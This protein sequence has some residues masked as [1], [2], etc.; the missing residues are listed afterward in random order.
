MLLQNH[1][2]WQALLRQRSLLEQLAL[3]QKLARLLLSRS[4]LEQSR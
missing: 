3:E 1:Y 4:R 2:H